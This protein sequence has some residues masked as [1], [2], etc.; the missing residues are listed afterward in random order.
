M[1]S[2]FTTKLGKHTVIARIVSWHKHRSQ[3][4]MYLQ[5]MKSVCYNNHILQ[6]RL[7]CKVTVL[8]CV[9]AVFV[10]LQCLFMCSL[11]LK[12]PSTIH[13]L[14]ESP[15]QWMDTQNDSPSILDDDGDVQ[16]SYIVKVL[17]GDGK[18]G[19][20]VHKLCTSVYERE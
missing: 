12:H 1:Y 7:V 9:L 3:I 17:D 14:S 8:I 4:P 20:K 10:S 5:G 2:F 18:K 16:Y 6:T 11:Q 19:Y 15:Q 13:R